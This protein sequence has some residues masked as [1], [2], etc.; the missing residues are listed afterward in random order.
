MIHLG[1]QSIKVHPANMHD[2]VGAI[3]TVNLMKAKF[4][5][6]EKILADGGYKGETLATHI[7]NEL[8]CKIEIALR[9]DECPKKFS[10]IPK[11]WIVERSF[12]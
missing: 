7:Q 1:C 8:G 3:E 4:P 9:P 2:S 5:R 6:L 11:R 10:V 12:A